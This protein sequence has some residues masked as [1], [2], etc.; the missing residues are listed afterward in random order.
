MEIY[1]LKKEEYNIPRRTGQQM[2]FGV[3]TLCLP[4]VRKKQ[5]VFAYKKMRIA[6]RFGI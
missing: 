5:F 2:F 4:R 1:I 6:E 3:K